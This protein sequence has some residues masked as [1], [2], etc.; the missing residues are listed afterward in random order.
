[1][2]DQP[3]Y[4]VNDG[5][6]TLGPEVIRI[7]SLLEAHFLSW[8]GE[9]NADEMLFPSLVPV[10]K[11]DK[12]DYFRNFPHLALIATR[13]RS[14][15]LTD[16]ARPQVNR[17]ISSVNLSDGDYVLP[18]AACYYVFI[19]LQNTTLEESRCI[20]TIANCF[21]NETEYNGLQRL[22][23]FGMREIVCIG[24]TE[25]VQSQLMALKERI[26]RFVEEIGLSLEIKFG[27]DPFYE[28]Y[29]SRALMQKLFPVKEEF[30]YD[31]E[32]SIASINFHRN[33]FGERCQIRMVNGDVAFSGCVAFGIER[34][35][36]ALLDHFGGD[37]EAIIKAL[38]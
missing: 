38:L 34:W 11:L 15:N 21:R 37:T 8:A 3:L 16:F 36:N 31:A 7:R 1:M 5:L 22:R 25:A 14:E 6:A 29:C 12:F 35:L 4:Y 24:P 19:H 23:G 18:S 13:I 9:C 30:V 32:V 2:T 27:I 17:A 26:Q 28:P 33:F 20:T 10:R